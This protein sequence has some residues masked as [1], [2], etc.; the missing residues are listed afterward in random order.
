MPQVNQSPQVN[1]ASAYYAC[2]SFLTTLYPLPY[3]YAPLGLTH[4]QY[5]VLSH[6]HVLACAVTSLERLPPSSSSRA[7]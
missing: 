1:L 4:L 2:L 7:S 3:L 5:Q 6:L